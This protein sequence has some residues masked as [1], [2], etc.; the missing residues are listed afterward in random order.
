VESIGAFDRFAAVDYLYIR[1]TCGSRPQV[2][3]QWVTVRLGPIFRDERATSFNS[4]V[5]TVGAATGAECPSV[6]GVSDLLTR[7]T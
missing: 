1:G 6:D 5:R 2:P 3:P 7:L 4:E